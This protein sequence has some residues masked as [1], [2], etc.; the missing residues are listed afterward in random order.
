MSEYMKYAKMLQEIPST[1]YPRIWCELHSCQWP[2]EFGD[3]GWK[4]ETVT[5]FDENQLCKLIEEIVG[6]KAVLRQWKK[7]SHPGFTDQLFDD[8][9][10]STHEGAEKGRYLGGVA[11]GPCEESGSKSNKE[12]IHILC[13]S[14]S[15]LLGL[16]LGAVLTFLVML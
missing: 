1:E 2:A 3:G 9:W 7:E 14:L 12:P 13:S 4:P 15:L 10:A 6:I 16:A 11:E 8:W 5:I